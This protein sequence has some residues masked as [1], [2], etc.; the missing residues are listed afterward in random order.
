[1]A[2]TM[3]VY[4]DGDVL[5]AKVI[6]M[7]SLFLVSMIC[8]CAPMLI[9]LKFDWF[10]KSA[11][12]NMR[13]SNTLV[14]GLLAFGGGVLFAT[15][16]MHL[17]PEVDEN[18]QQLQDAGEL[19]DLPIYLAAL[20]MCCGFFMMYLVEEL[21]HV[22]INRRENKTAN[23][24]FTRVLSIRKNSTEGDASEGVPI[25]KDVEAKPSNQGHGHSHMGVSGSDDS[26]VAALRG[27]LIVLALS[28][29]ELF[30]G[31]AVGLESSAANVWYMFGAVSAHKYI[32]GFCIG[33]ELLAAGTKRWLSV[34]YVFTFSFVSALGIGIGILLVGGAGAAEAGLYS[35]VLQGLACGTLVYVVFF[36]VWRQ[37]RTGLLQFV[38]SVL[39]FALMVTLE[40]IVEL[41]A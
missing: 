29:H 39:G 33:V 35:V 34:L 13:T 24:S 37:D 5:R 19:P 30:E 41:A 28:I 14:M 25:P 4:S 12:P 6:T 38:C 23:T 15:T 27:L 21:V 9:S 8:G 11:G 32:I 18:V 20:I 36:E 26:I 17:L 7:V 40:V 2:D 31:L 22:Y 1:M 3:N 16:F 10:T